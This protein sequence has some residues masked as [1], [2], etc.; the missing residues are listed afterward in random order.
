MDNFGCL[1]F[2][3]VILAMCVGWIYLGWK[4]R[5][6]AWEA[7]QRSLQDLKQRPNDANLR[8]KAVR[9]GREY[10]DL[11]R[12]KRGVTVYDE[13]AIMNDIGAACAAAGAAAV[14]ADHSSSAPPAQSIEQ[15]LSMLSNLRAQGLIDEEEFR[16]RRKRILDEV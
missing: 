6:V 13:V 5:Q 3:I 2:F 4:A 15:R 9:L 11:T 1:L 8:E 14:S 12:K 7:Y 16:E 10:S